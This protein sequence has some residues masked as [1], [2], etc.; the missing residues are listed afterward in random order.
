MLF[1]KRLLLILILT[2]S[3]QTLTKADDIRD[4]EI[5]GLTLGDSLLEMYSKKEIKEFLKTS[6]NFYPSSKTYFL[7]AT[8]GKDENFHH[9]K[10]YKPKSA[11]NGYLCGTCDPFLILLSEVLKIDIE[12][13]FLGNLI[14]Y[15]NDGHKTYAFG[16]N[17]GHFYKK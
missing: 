15:K 11:K 13:T 14:H 17:R 3:F 10:D 6:S 5:Q 8:G 12:H 2:F 9:I 7:L 1:M 16:S 4:F